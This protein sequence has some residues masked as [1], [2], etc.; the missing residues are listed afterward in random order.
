MPNLREHRFLAG[1]LRDKRVLDL[2]RTGATAEEMLR[3]GG[4]RLDTSPLADATYDAVLARAESPEEL[5]TC[6]A[7]LPALLTG[8]AL[9]ALWAHLGPRTEDGVFRFETLLKLLL[10][11]FHVATYA[12]GDGETFRAEWNSYSDSVLIFCRHLKPMSVIP[13]A[14]GWDEIYGGSIRGVLPFSLDYLRAWLADAPTVKASALKG[15]LLFFI[16]PLPLYN[17]PVVYQKFFE[18]YLILGEQY[19]S[20]GWAVSYATTGALKRLYGS[21]STYAPEDFGFPPPIADWR[22]VYRKMLDRRSDPHDPCL[23]FWS[24]YIRSL[25]DRVQ[26]D[27]VFV[28]NQSALL[29]RLTAE[30]GIPLIHNEHA[31]DRAPRPPTYYFDPQ[32][33]NAGCSLRGLWPRFAAL[34]LPECCLELVRIYRQR[35][36]Q[37]W[38]GPVLRADVL[39]SLSLDPARPTALIPLQVENDSNVLGN[40][41]FASIR[42]FCNHV[43]DKLSGAGW[44]AIVKPHPADPLPAPALSDRPNVRVVGPYYPMGPLVK[45]ADAVHTI[46]STTG[47]EA[48]IA[49]KTVETYGASAY[50]GIALGPE[51]TDRFLFLASMLYPVSQR[52]LKSAKLQEPL[53]LRAIERKPLWPNP[54]SIDFERL[55]SSIKS[56]WLSWEDR[57]FPATVFPVQ[58][59]A[60]GEKLARSEARNEKLEQENIRLHKEIAEAYRE[61]TGIANRHLEWKSALQI[62]QHQLHEERQKPPTVIQAPPPP[63]PPPAAAEEPK[64]RLHTLLDRL[65][66]FTPG[67][68]RWTIRPLYLNLIYYRLYPEQRPRKPRPLL[69]LAQKVPDEFGSSYEPYIAFKKRAYRN[70]PREF[71]SL[72]SGEIPELISVVLPVYNGERYVAASID[73]VLSQTYSNLELIV[74]DDGSTD[75]TAEILAKYEDE[76]RVRIIHQP[77]RKLPGAL[78][79]GFAHASGELWTWT[80][81]D[82]IMEPDM[83]ARL[84]AFL[85]ARPG[86]QT[87][88]GDETIIDDNGNEVLNSDFCPLYQTPR[89]SGTICWPR[90]PGE[91]S[92]VQNN[93]VGGCFLY[94]AWAARLTGPYDEHAFGF[95]DYDFWMRMNDLFGIAHLGEAQAL[96]RYRLHDS[97]LSSRDKEL[98]ITERVRQ[99]MQFAGERREFFAQPFDIT[100]YGPHPWFAE[101]A[102]AYRSAGHNVFELSTFSAETLYRHEVTRAFE[103]RLAIFGEKPDEPAWLRALDDGCV[104]AQIAADPTPKADLRFSERA[105]Q[106][107]VFS[108]Q[109]LREMLYPL[110]AGSNS[111]I[112][113]R[114]HRRPKNTHQVPANA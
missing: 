55:A 7:Q 14:A 36:E 97:S 94:R 45:A 38:L 54:D 15:R 104:I 67:F 76:T 81:H 10:E 83:L 16:Q 40:S 29:D 17:D 110:L 26:P 80:S 100:F 65:Q 49:G 69:P 21:P 57:A 37:P 95:E 84:A 28:W 63:P 59:D 99:F 64:D 42:D 113:A 61:K 50:S 77:N 43:L 72:T 103:K 109:S 30:R 90:D 105:G 102:A 48:L 35:Y 114:K 12:F 1:L 4:N 71:A 78:N 93:Y 34:P 108:T 74:V 62:V 11:R 9:L 6:L 22:E 66:S 111:I 18:R 56:D 32:G 24:N 23:R 5:A 25:L 106:S 51:Q 13:G 46:S 82:N 33:V 91:L 8:N 89:G 92:F 39:R 68:V 20:L 98:Q 41:E 52:V 101:M 79:A 53:L 31:L 3:E 44:N 85:K 2:S 112:H 88:Y 87:V 19:R 73:S 107:G 60:L 58:P 96:Y 75:R 27:A 86:V 47:Y 70:L